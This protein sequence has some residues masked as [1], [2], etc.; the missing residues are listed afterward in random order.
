MSDTPKTDSIEVWSDNVGMGILVV[1][2]REMRQVEKQ[3]AEARA[4]IEKFNNLF[5]NGIDCFMSPCERHS[6]ENTPPFDEFI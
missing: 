1:P 4:E 5:K 3:L 2:A 6:G